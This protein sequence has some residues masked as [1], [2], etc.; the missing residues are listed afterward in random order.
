[1][2]VYSSAIHSSDFSAEV[3]GQPVSVGF[4][5]ENVWQ[6]N[7]SFYSSAVHSSD[8]SSAVGGQPVFH[9]LSAKIDY[10]NV[11]VSIAFRRSPRS[12]RGTMFLVDAQT[13]VVSIAF[14]RSPRSRRGD[15]HTD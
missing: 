15:T 14:R 5:Q 3:S 10:L 11:S 9:C 8:L 7:G 4:S 2:R 12:R 1:M 6:G 13:F